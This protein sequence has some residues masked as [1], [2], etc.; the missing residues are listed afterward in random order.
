MDVLLHFLLFPLKKYIIKVIESVI[1][2][3]DNILHVSQNFLEYLI[4][5]LLS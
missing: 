5:K 4:T 3:I 2:D 1:S